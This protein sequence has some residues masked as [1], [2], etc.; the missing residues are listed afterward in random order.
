[1]KF[2]SQLCRLNERAFLVDE[3]NLV[4]EIADK[5]IVDDVR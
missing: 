1:M 2:N 3:S 4:D 5:C